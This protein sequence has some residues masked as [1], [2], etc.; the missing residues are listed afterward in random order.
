MNTIFILTAE[1]QWEK[2][3]MIRGRLREH[4]PYARVR[5]V[6]FSPDMRHRSIAWDAKARFGY[7]EAVIM[8]AEVSL[9]YE[10][11]RHSF[12]N[13]L[14]FGQKVLI[15][16]DDANRPVDKRIHFGGRSRSAY[17]YQLVSPS[18]LRAACSRLI[19]GNW[20]RADR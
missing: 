6:K 18:A 10:C 8:T 12:I 5:V 19:A 2:T 16:L 20:M 17:W 15:V 13:D 4:A 14:P 7:P 9:L 1:N 3:M 11:S